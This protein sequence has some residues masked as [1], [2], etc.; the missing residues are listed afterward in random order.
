MLSLVVLVVVAAVVL[1]A[2]VGLF[3][4]FFKLV[5]GLIGLLFGAMVAASA[6]GLVLLAGGA[7]VAAILLAIAVALAPVWLPL[8]F[9]GWLF[10]LLVRPA[11]R[12]VLMP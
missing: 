2:G 11:P 4:L 10:W 3:G 7:L 9:V 12:P 5:F 1:R 6:I 8:V